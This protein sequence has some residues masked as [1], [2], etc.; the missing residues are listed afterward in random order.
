MLELWSKEHKKIDEL[1]TGFLSI[2]YR[3]TYLEKLSTQTSVFSLCIPSSSTL[4]SIVIVSALNRYAKFEH[5]IAALLD[6]HPAL[7]TAITIFY[8]SETLSPQV[9]GQW[10]MMSHD[11]NNPLVEVLNSQYSLDVARHIPGYSYTYRI[12]D[13]SPMLLHIYEPDYNG[14]LRCMSKDEQKFGF[15]V[16][17]S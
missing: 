10:Y 2:D 17:A 11:G 13:N 7:L 8:V 3:L 9:T 16:L 6:A 14:M 5:S 4:P 15:R 12:E 1:V